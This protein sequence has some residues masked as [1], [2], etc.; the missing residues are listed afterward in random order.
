MRV[1]THQRIRY[2]DAYAKV[3]KGQSCFDRCRETATCFECSQTI[4]QHRIIVWDFRVPLWNQ[5]SIWVSRPCGVCRLLH[6]QATL[7][8]KVHWGFVGVV[9][10]LRSSLNT[11]TL[12]LN[13]SRAIKSSSFSARFWAHACEGLF[14]KNFVLFF[15]CRLG[16]LRVDSCESDCLIG[17]GVYCFKSRLLLLPDSFR[18]CWEGR[19]LFLI[20]Y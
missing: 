4:L 15:S 11:L 1:S 10:L 8:L 6:P 16:C 14:E 5:W 2:L 17:N 13:E 18:V 3:L 20:V 12:G 7:G 9:R 19:T